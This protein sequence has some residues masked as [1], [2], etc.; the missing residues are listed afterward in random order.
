MSNNEILSIDDQT[1]V[2]IMNK[3]HRSAAKSFKSPPQPK[4][5][6]RETLNDG[7]KDVFINVLSYSRIANQLSEFDPVSF[8]LKYAFCVYFVR[9]SSQTCY[10]PFHLNLT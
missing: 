10:I 2:S 5:C 1:L 4:F 3:R 7:S 6:I 8:A 9:K